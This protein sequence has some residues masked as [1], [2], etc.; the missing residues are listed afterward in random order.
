MF[1]F[2]INDRGRRL[3]RRWEIVSPHVDY[4]TKLSVSA[5]PSNILKA[6]IFSIADHGHSYWN[7][8]FVVPFKDPRKLPLSLKKKMV[9]SLDKH[10]MKLIE[11]NCM[12]Y[13]ILGIP[14]K[15]YPLDMLVQSIMEVYP[16]LYFN[17]E[18]TQEELKKLAS[19][20]PKRQIVVDN[21]SEIHYIHMKGLKGWP[22]FPKNADGL[23]EL[24][25]WLGKY[26]AMG[27]YPE[28]KKLI[29]ILK[30]K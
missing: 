20:S 29:S 8:P 9:S 24:F 15:D 16:I 21:G 22:R 11:N 12:D 25:T 17:K 5:S 2:S 3:Q 4:L 30:C 6:V 19:I 7:L 1:S 27:K 18:L 10:M 14:F 28:Y 23:V 13:H 26:P